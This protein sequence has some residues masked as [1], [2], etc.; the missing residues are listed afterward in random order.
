MQD[1]RSEIFDTNDKIED[2][3]KYE[4]D[5]LEVKNNEAKR[6]AVTEE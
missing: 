2:I 5:M 3:V 4:A 1:F 6:T